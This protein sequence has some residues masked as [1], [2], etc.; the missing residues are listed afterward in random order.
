M[1]SRHR[2]WFKRSH[3]D[4]GAGT[5]VDG[6]V[7]DDDDVTDIPLGVRNFPQHLPSA[8]HHH[9]VAD[10]VHSSDTSAKDSDADATAANDSRP[11]IEANIESGAPSTSSS[12]AFSPQPVCSGDSRC[13]PALG[14]NSNTAAD[15]HNDNTDAVVVVVVAKSTGMSSD[16]DGAGAMNAP[17]G[18]Q[19]PGCDNAADVSE[20]FD[21][22]AQEQYGRDGNENSENAAGPLR[23]TARSVVPSWRVITTGPA[24]VDHHL[25]S[26]RTAW[27]I[28][29]TTKDDTLAASASS[30]S[31]TVANIDGT[32]M[33]I[34]RGYY[35]K[36][37]FNKNGVFIENIRKI[38]NLDERNDQ[39]GRNSDNDEVDVHHKVILNAQTSSTGNHVAGGPVALMQD[40]SGSDDV[41]DD[42]VDDGDDDDGATAA[43]AAA[44][45]DAEA[46][47]RQKIALMSVPLSEHYVITS[48]GRIAKNADALASDDVITQF[49]EGLAGDGDYQQQQ[50]ETTVMAD[51]APASH[52]SSAVH[53]MKQMQQPALEHSGSPAKGPATATTT[54]SGD[55]G[56]Q[57]QPMC[58]VMGE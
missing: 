33:P 55:G 7:D 19:Q 35:E 11:E 29:A 4:D 27:P 24:M 40:D 47:E 15:R 25:P 45:A 38:G 14:T 22:K 3:D 56:S 48:S 5:E 57:Q 2:E 18:V 36:T 37:I 58:I 30:A 53:V 32:A 28:I 49:R 6:T 20:T 13:Q 52:S 31:A 8:A 44:A 16:V 23:T 54:G 41:D 10:D 34:E 26:E 21:G 12:S 43:A 39:H 51:D 9:S 42:D 46:R 50:Q 17:N 1:S